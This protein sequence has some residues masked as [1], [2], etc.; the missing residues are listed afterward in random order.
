MAELTEYQ[1]KIQY[2]LTELA[3]Y[4]SSDTELLWNLSTFK[5]L[6]CLVYVF[7]VPSF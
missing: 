2:L 6:N 7:F 5:D 3:T 4:G 1:T